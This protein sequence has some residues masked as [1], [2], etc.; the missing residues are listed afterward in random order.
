MSGHITAAPDSFEREPPMSVCIEITCRDAEVS[1]KTRQLVLGRAQVVDDYADLVELC[2]VIIRRRGAGGGTG[3]GFAVS[4]D[5][6]LRGGRTV[7][8]C[9]RDRH[10]YFE[11]LEAAV[12]EAFHELR[13]WLHDVAPAWREEAG[14][15]ACRGYSCELDPFDRLDDH[16]EPQVMV[17]SLVGAHHFVG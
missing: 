11:T 3:R 5:L 7:A 13:C 4:I 16:I 6:I 1:S 10:V 12:D 15:Y 8:S 2:H 14:E 9:L 17:H